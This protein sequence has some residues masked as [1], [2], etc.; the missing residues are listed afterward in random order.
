MLVRSTKD[1]MTIIKFLETINIILYVFKTVSPKTL[2]SLERMILFIRLSK[3]VLNKPLLS[4]PQTS[5]EQPEN[6]S[7]NLHG[8]FL[9]ICFIYLSENNRCRIQGFQCSTLYEYIVLFRR[10]ELNNLQQKHDS[11][12]SVGT[13]CSYQY[14]P[15]NSNYFI[16]SCLTPHLF[17]DPYYSNVL[18]YISSF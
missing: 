18:H 11:Y 15:M 14:Y 3:L 10:Q 1:E 13:N 12:I 9:F 16:I 6:I 4:A 7:S 8:T 2:D 17:T 5:L